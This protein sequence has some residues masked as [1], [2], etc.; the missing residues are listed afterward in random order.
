MLNL[1]NVHSYGEFI[2]EAKNEYAVYIDGKQYDKN[3][4]YRT[5]NTNYTQALQIAEP[6]S[7]VE[8][9][10]VRDNKGKDV[11]ELKKSKEVAKKSTTSKTSKKAF[12]KV[13]FIKE[14]IFNDIIGMFN[15]SRT[16]VLYDGKKL[17]SLKN[18]DIKTG[19]VKL[20]VDISPKDILFGS[21]PEINEPYPDMLSPGVEIKK[22]YKIIVKD[23]ETEDGVSLL[24]DFVES[25]IKKWNMTKL[26]HRI[27][28]KEEEQAYIDLRKKAAKAENK[29]TPFI[30]IV[31]GLEVI[32]NPNFGKS[33]DKVGVS[34]EDIK[35]LKD[36]WYK[37]KE[38]EEEEYYKGDLEDDDIKEPE[39]FDNVQLDDLDSLDF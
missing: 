33:K 19:N 20:K 24:N 16:S 18:D 3:G 31:M 22:P 27:E 30:T 35:S 10:K 15:T 4:D 17:S 28:L 25:A 11:K 14:I 5:S 7:K 34:D 37:Q 39:D 8:M 6:G 38:K 21:M 1:K 12:N 2:N 36:D 26:G 9:F 13:K 29:E 23:V 32:D